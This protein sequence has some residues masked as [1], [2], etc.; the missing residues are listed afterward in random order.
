[1]KI[2]IVDNSIDLPS[3]MGADFRRYL[4]GEVWVRRGPDRDLPG[5]PEEFTHVI[6]SGSK[7]SILD[8]GPWI[9]ELMEY[10]RRIERIGTPLLGICYGHQ[11]VAR[12]LGGDQF[13]RR[14]NTPEFGWVEIAQEKPHPLLVDLPNRFYSFQAHFEEVHQLPRGFVSTAKSPRCAIQAYY[15]DQK[16]IFGLQFHPER[17]A[18]EGEQSL[19][20]SKKSAPKDCIF[21][22]GKAESL[23]TENVA[24][25]IFKNFLA[26]KSAR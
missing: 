10:V 14:S 17:N 13:V 8:N 19:E 15:A 1:M 11:I 18:E 7:T 22:D 24:R 26:T 9:T 5:K 23:F 25:T 16:P 4:D 6:L 2:L 12:A 20:R 3:S 21:N